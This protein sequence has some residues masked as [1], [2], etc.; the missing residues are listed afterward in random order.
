MAAHF[1]I[2]AARVFEN[3]YTNGIQT[4]PNSE[5]QIRELA[6]LESDEQREVWQQAVEQAGGKVP[7]GRIVK[8]IIKRLKEKPIPQLSLTYKRGDAFTL[9]GLTGA[10]RRYNNCWAIVREVLEFSLK[11]ETHD[12]MLL[13]KPDN[14]D[15]IDD[16]VV[17]RQLPALLKR[18]QQLR[19]RELDRGA[20][21]ILESL[22][23]RMYLTDLEEE[24]LIWLE[25]Y[26]QL[27]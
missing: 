1:K 3:L 17:R 20:E 14:L 24:L 10:E 12:A 11:V 7:S 6:T 23:K 2:A 27:R 22:G 21:V 9:Q 16:R 19:Q 15:P 5:R 25:N 8:G 13:V 18:I 4:L 26:Y